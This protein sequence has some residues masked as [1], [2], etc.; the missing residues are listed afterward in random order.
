MQEE[1][2]EEKKEEEITPAE[3]KARSSNWA[4][5]EEWKG[6]EDDW[7]DYKEFN[8]RGELMSRINEQSSILHNL[9]NQISTRD[10]AI[11]DLKE[12]HKDNSERAYEKALKT[13]R[14]EK[15]VAVDESDGSRVVEIDEEI[16]TLRDKH[17]KV[18]ADAA[19]TETTPPEIADWL[20]KQDNQWYNQNKFLRDVADSIAR[21][22]RE[23]DPGVL[24]GE[25]LRR[26]STKIKSELPQHFKG[27]V[28]GVDDGSG[29]LQ[30]R[31]TGSGSKPKFSDLDDDQQAVCRRFEKLG[32]MT[33]AEY[34][35]ELVA[36]G[37][38]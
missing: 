1:Q 3:Q 36:A 6:S 25:L 11:D 31:P 15:V 22:I 27:Q 32:V 8:F 23:Q 33:K 24:P 18:N 30:S 13:L 29:D 28:Q 34:I 37:D 7:I 5:K 4:P 35:E 12:I 17:R 10:K 26:M 16:D 38:L 9:K 21:D 20:G 2:I 19:P 14:D